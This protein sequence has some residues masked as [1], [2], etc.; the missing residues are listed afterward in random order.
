M[1]DLVAIIPFYVSLL[2]EGLENFEILGLV[3]KIFSEAE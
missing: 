3:I 1:I 2:L